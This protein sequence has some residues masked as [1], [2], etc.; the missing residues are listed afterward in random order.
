[1]GGNSKIAITIKEKTSNESSITQDICNFAQAY[2][3]RLKSNGQF[4]ANDPHYC[5]IEELYS[6]EKADKISGDK[7]EPVRLLLGQ[8]R[9]NAQANVH[10]Q[11]SS[12]SSATSSARCPLASP[13]SSPFLVEHCARRCGLYSASDR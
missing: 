10:A 7:A 11:H 2:G 12:A 3:A 13:D 4:E 6:R 5:P 8:H 9:N 1:M